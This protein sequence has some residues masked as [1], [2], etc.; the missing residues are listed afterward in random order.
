MGLNFV[1][2]L[3]QPKTV[4]QYT[5]YIPRMHPH[6]SSEV[7]GIVVRILF[8]GVIS[9][10]IY[11]HSKFKRERVIRL[12]IVLKFLRFQ[13]EG[14]QNYYQPTLLGRSFDEA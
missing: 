13:W 7:T 6:L 12:L 5:T 1:L 9:S 14:P 2:E 10:L 4:S 3:L 8:E 11:S